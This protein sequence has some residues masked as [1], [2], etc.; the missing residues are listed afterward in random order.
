MVN[1]QASKPLKPFQ[2]LKR[3][4]SQHID[5]SQFASKPLKPFQGLK[6]IGGYYQSPPT[7]CSASK[8]L[9]PFQGLKLALRA[10]RALRYSSFK[11]SKTLSGIETNDF[12]SKV[13]DAESFKASKTL[14]GIETAVILGFAYL[15]Y[16][17]ASKPLKPFQ[18]LKHFG[19]GTGTLLNVA[20]KPLK[21][22][23][24]LKQCASLWRLKFFD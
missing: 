10:C 5:G 23:Q 11:A 7:G 22:F 13:L 15:N 12:R 1:A 9:K 8:P 19:T 6:L 18:G 4:R 24:G 3:N 16:S 21:P 2:G 14:S 20:S 17:E